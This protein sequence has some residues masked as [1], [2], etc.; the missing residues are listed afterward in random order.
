MPDTGKSTLK[1]ESYPALDNLAELLVAKKTMKVEIGGHTDSQG[2]DNANLKLS[3]NRA[4][5]VCAYLVT[6]GVA[7][8]RLVPKGYGETKPRTT[9]DT[10][11]GRARNRR[12]EVK[13]L[14]E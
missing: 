14:E 4:K 7:N 9:N 8:D 12:T 6:K 1:P 13:I 11:E 5:A 3:D 2:D 10:A